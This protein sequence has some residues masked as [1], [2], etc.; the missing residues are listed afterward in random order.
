MGLGV[1]QRFSYGL[2]VL[3]AREGEKENGCIINTAMQVTANPNCISV[4]VNKQNYTHDMILR[5]GRLA[6][7][8]IS[9]EADFAL[10]TRFG[11]QSGREVNKFEGFSDVKRTADGLLAV[12]AGTNAYVSAK[13]VTTQD[14]GTHTLFIAE[15]TEMEELSDAPSATYAFYHTSI[16]PQPEK[17]SSQTETKQ[18]VWRCK[19][20]GYEYVGDTLPEDYICPLCKHP[21]SDFE[22]VE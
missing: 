20:C 4:A 17:K 22:K 12:T 3:T 10:F 16:K 14:L 9:E 6:V 11:F 2:F 13:V 19:I 8:I 15:V 5:T 21:A 18:T 7:S 1:M